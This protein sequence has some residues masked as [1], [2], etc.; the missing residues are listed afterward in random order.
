MYIKN[1]FEKGDKMVTIKDVAE[2]LDEKI[3]KDDNFIVFTFYELR[4]KRNLS[5]EDTTK[6]L[7]Y[8]KIRLKNNGYKVYYTGQKYEYQNDVKTVL[9]NQLMVAIKFE[10]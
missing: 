3:E 6:F 8:S 5:K 2:C 10:W 1:L 9:D 4:V 7:E